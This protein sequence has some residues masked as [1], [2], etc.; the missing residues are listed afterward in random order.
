[1]LD[2]AQARPSREAIGFFRPRNMP[3]PVSTESRRAWKFDRAVF[4]EDVDS[5]LVFRDSIAIENAVFSGSK[6]GP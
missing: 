4:V 2:T 1:M 5:L 6:A 3:L